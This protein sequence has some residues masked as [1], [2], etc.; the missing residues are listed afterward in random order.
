MRI[1]K[2]YGLLLFG[3]RN[4]KSWPP[5]E[6]FKTDADRRRFRRSCAADGTE[7]FDRNG[8]SWEIFLFSIQR[9]KNLVGFQT[10]PTFLT[11]L[12][13]LLLLLLLCF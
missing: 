3:N 11:Y 8:S 6:S 4:K 2:E 7:K 9:E 10:A 12:L 1:K 5:S 13:L